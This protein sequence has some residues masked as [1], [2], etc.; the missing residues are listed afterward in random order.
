MSV[1]LSHSRAFERF[2]DEDNDVTGL[3]AYALYKQNIQQRRRAGRTAP[4]PGERDPAPAELNAYRGQAVR[5]LDAF[6]EAAV[7]RAAPDILRNALLVSQQQATAVVV[8]EVR[9]RTGLVATMLT[10]LVVWLVTIG[11]T[12]LL[13]LAEPDWVRNLVEHVS[14]ARP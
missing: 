7:Q 11:L 9:A 10:G 5:L 2:V 14:P 3:V 12:V 6:G 8:A 13:A 1:S 4:D